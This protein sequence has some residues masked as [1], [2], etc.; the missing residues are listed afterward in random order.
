M[1]ENITGHWALFVVSVVLTF[2][3]AP[4]AA[5]AAPG[6]TELVSVHAKP[7]EQFESSFPI[8]VSGDGRFVAFAASDAG[9]YAP[10]EPDDR[11]DCLVRDRLRGQTLIANRN[12]AGVIGNASSGCDQVSEDGRYVLFHSSA[13]NLVSGDTNAQPGQKSARL[14]VST[15]TGEKHSIGLDGTGH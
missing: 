7:P 3:A 2:A 6:E 13:S 4:R 5:L 1:T 10:Q 15:A 14:V 12:S 8:G 11:P 9:A